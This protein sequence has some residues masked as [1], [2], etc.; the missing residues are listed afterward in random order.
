MFGFDSPES[1]Y[2][3]CS[4]KPKLKRITTPTLMIQA[5]DDPFMTQAVLPSPAELSDATTLE[6]RR[7]G[8]VG[9]VEGLPF[10]PH[11]W[12]ERRIPEWLSTWL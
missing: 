11:Y 5:S 7:G 6:V 8:H 4:A 3:A 10:R 2:A 1:Y 12:L 9:F